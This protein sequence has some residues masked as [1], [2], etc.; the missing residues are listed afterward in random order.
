MNKKEEKKEIARVFRDALD[1]WKQDNGFGAIRALSES[2]GISTQTLYNIM[3]GV[4][5]PRFE[6]QQRLSQYLGPQ[7]IELPKQLEPKKKGRYLPKT[8]IHQG[9][10]GDPE[11]KR[12]LR[13]DILEKRYP[14]LPLYIRILEN[15]LEIGDETL[16]RHAE[17][18]IIDILR[19]KTHPGENNDEQ[20]S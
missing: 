4:S 5:A 19:K 2:T 10:E 3:N 15:G 20:T 8:E 18:M 12:E 16:V 11:T 17:K 13:H 7:Y 1:R 14:N 6:T 9:E